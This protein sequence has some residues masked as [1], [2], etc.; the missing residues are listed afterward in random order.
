M[1]LRIF[2]IQKFCIHDGPGIRTTVFVKGCPLD[3]AWCH[4]P[5]SISPATQTMFFK[6]LCIGCEVCLGK[7]EILSECP[8]GARVSVGYDAKIDDIIQ[9]VMKDEIYY[10]NGGGV[11]VSGGE[12]LSQ[13]ASVKELLLRLKNQN[14]H[15]AVE[16]SCFAPLDVVAELADTADLVIAD[17][18]LFT[19]EK[20]K[21]FTGV[22]N[23]II[24]EN[25]AYL[26]EK[27]PERLWISIPIIPGVHDDTEF[28]KMAAYLMSLKNPVKV[29]LIPYDEFGISKSNALG[30]N[31]TIFSGD[32]NALTLKAEK[33]MRQLEIIHQP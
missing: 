19:S 10:E 13:W 23:T 28:E 32:V 14:I 7:S 31:P 21:E 2:D 33:Y 12:P 6:E 24:K 4:N 8:S 25:I 1:K 20:H 5:E 16:T 18:K 30:K 26:N 27:I 11:T 17:F 22:D 3:C 9:E 15:T 29:R